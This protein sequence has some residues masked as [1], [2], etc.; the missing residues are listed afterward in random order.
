MSA[1]DTANRDLLTQLKM[2]AATAIDFLRDLAEQAGADCEVTIVISHPDTAEDSFIVG[3]HD[4]DRLFEI[5]THLSTGTTVA[6]DVS[7]TLVGADEP[8]ARS[9][10]Q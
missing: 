7:S 4:M 2:T 10:V 6:S 5:L 3:Q 9:G 8:V 1:I